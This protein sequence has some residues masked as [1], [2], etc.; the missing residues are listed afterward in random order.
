M[1]LRGKEKLQKKTHCEAELLKANCCQLYQFEEE[2]LHELQQ[3][4]NCNKLQK[5]VIL[6]CI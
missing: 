6:Q 4:K 2:N 3:I 1:F 5:S